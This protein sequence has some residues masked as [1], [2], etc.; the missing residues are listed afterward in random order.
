MTPAPIAILSNPL[1]TRNQGAGDWLAPLVTGHSW[2]HRYAFDRVEEIPK[3]LADCEKAGIGTLVIDGGDGTA[4]RV[5]SGLLN[6]GPYATLPVLTLLPSGKTNMTAEAWSLRGDREKTLAELIKRSAD[7]QLEH[8][9]QKQSVLAIHDGET[10][11]P[12]H[13]A[14]FGGAD[15]VEGILYCRRAIYPLGLPNL[16]SHGAAIAVLFWR[17]MVSGQDGGDINVAF[18]EH[19]ESE[20]GH[21]SI[22]LATTMDRMLLGLRPIQ[23][24]GTG[25]VHYMSLRPGATAVLSTLPGLFRRRVAP[26]S[27][28]TV[29]RSR[30][31]TLAMSG[32]YTLDGEIFETHPDRPLILDGHR[33]L[34]FIRW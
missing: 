10:T 14:F 19:S 9:V 17:V 1:S 16:I 8:F 18:D 32:S 29:R 28:R 4:G 24:T 23:E 6:D 5:F 21:F 11:A 30:S 26:G 7:N 2:I 34:K 22:I 27:K 31:V 15:V 3:I 20:M 12:R 33:K 25:P 13:G